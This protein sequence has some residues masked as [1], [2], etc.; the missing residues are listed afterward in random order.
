MSASNKRLA[1]SLPEKLNFSKHMDR[2]PYRTLTAIACDLEIP[3]TTLNQIISNC[4][5]IDQPLWKRYTAGKKAT[6]TAWRLDVEDFNPS[7][8]WYCCALFLLLN[9]T[10]SFKGEKCIGGKRSKERVTIL[11]GANIDGCEKLPL[12]IGKAAKPRCFKN[13][14]SLPGSIYTF[15]MLKWVYRT[16]KIVLFLDHFSAHPMETSVLRN[17]R[18]EFLSLNTT[19]CLQPMDQGIIKNFKHHFRSCH[20]KTFLRD[21]EANKPF[22]KI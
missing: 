5:T 15:G 16:G 1:F 13:I 2:N 9:K 11:L 14:K 19:A 12:V 7:N 20:C 3:V 10:F 21:L 4:A 6:E 22:K 17:I 18:I 8:G